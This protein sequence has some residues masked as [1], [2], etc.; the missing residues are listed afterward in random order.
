MNARLPVFLLVVLHTSVT[1]A[2]ALPPLPP[3]PEPAD[4]VVKYSEDIRPIL[5]ARC[6][7]C[8]GERKQESL[9]RMDNRT[10]AINSG[11]ERSAIVP[12][13]SEDSLV[14]KLIAGIDPAYFHM[15]PKG[16]LLTAEEVGLIRAWID[17]GVAWE[18]EDAAG[19]AILGRQRPF[20]GFP[21]RWVVETTGQ[22]A[23]AGVWEPVAG[24]GP[25]G[26]P[27]VSFDRLDNPRLESP[28]MLWNQ[29][30]QF[31]EGTVSVRLK[32]VGGETDRGGGLIWR[33]RDGDNYYVAWCSLRE[34]RLC[35]LR[36]R[37]GVTEEL[38]RAEFPAPA[39]E[40]VTLAIRERNNHIVIE[41][42]GSAR[43]AMELPPSKE[44]GGIGVCTKGDVAALFTHP[45][46]TSD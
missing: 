4:K 1:G 42:D 11:S 17:Q 15:P 31:S 30:V 14:V 12:G 24:A 8:H 10:D 32:A 23:P 36:V 39:G 16:D 37:Q 22:E 35:L 38:A 9:Y 7:K 27:C 13:K 2:S 6:V 29:E 19:G 44:P 46:V 40:W 18:S 26:E 3:L 20:A 33:V 5:S 45:V 21:G 34:K 43:I 25:G 28:N 41:V